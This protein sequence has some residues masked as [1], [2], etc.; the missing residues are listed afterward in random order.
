ME[1]RLIIKKQLNA[2]SQLVWEV[3]TKKEHTSNW[4]FNFENDW[5][6]EVGNVFE[7]YAEDND[8]VQWL[9]KG[10]ILELVPNAKLSHSWYYPGYTGMSI[11]TWELKALS[12]KSTELT[13]IHDFIEPFDPSVPALDLKNFQAGWNQIINTQLPNY[14]KVVFV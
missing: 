6:L 1:N 14:L 4:Y 9:H 3:I 5:K 11:V 10:E 13:L 2:P 7:W 8:C 12:E